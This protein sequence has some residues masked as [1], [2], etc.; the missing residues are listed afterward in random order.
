MQVIAGKFLA[1]AHIFI[2]QYI[3]TIYRVT[4]K[5]IRMTAVIELKVVPSAGKQGCVFDK[6]GILKCYLKSPPEKGKANRELIK[7]LAKKL[8][9]TQADIAIISGQISRN[10]RIKIDT[11]LTEEQI[12][13]CLGIQ[14]QMKLF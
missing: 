14:K 13:E 12:H 8:N 2:S 6:S 3:L 11:E 9:L 10:K 7:L 4:V 1:I 5:G